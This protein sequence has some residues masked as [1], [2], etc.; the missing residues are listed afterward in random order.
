MDDVLS[1][2]LSR[3]KPKQKSVTKKVAR[4]P[5][6]RKTIKGVEHKCCSV[7]AAF[8]PLDAYHFYSQK[9]SKDGFCNQCKKCALAKNAEWQ[10]EN[11]ERCREKTNRYR[12]ANKEAELKK[13][14]KRSA[15]RDERISRAKPS[16]QSWSEIEKIYDE[17][18]RRR[19]LGEDVVVDHKIPISGKL[20]CGLHC[21]DNI[22]IIQKDGNN[23]K[24]NYHESEDI[25][26]S[27]HVDYKDIGVVKNGNFLDA[28]AVASFLLSN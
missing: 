28:D 18:A 1:R 23:T 24:R 12:E 2:I 13:S 9:R 8:L 11:K 3:V 5:V 27:M 10:A 17:A 6:L 15:L 16:W 14:R 19:A 25:L 26:L 7:C 4:A 21:K 20:V 22:R